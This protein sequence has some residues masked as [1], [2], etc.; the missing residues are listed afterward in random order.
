MGNYASAH[1][2]SEMQRSRASGALVAKD[3]SEPVEAGQGKLVTMAEEEGEDGLLA[4]PVTLRDR[5]VKKRP[6]KRVVIS[7]EPTADEAN[8]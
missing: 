5:G 3:T 1:R 4:A 6:Q 2:D 7:G 8:L